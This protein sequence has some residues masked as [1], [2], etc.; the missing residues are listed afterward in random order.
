MG[1]SNLG[2]KGLDF[3]S[4]VDSM[5]ASSSNLS[6]RYSGKMKSYLSFAKEVIKA[7]V[8]K[9]ETTG[10]VSHLRIRNHELSEELK[11]AKR[12]EKRMQ[13]EIDDLHSA[14]LDLRKE[15]RALKDGGGF[16]MHGIKG[17]KLGT[18]KERLSC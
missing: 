1:A 2:S 4:E 9:V 3:V 18:H 8:E 7:L 6:G 17:S 5:R 10:D 13:K 11:E 14:I 15:V 16:F 12:K